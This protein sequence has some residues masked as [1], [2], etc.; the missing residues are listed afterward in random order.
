MS[1]APPIAP[2]AHRHAARFTR[3]VAQA[4]HGLANG[5]KARQVAARAGLAITQNAQHHQAG[6]ERVQTLGRHVPAFER[7]GAKALDHHVGFG[8]QL[9]GYGL[10]FLLAQVQRHR[11]LVARLHLPPDGSAFLDQGPVAQRVA[12]RRTR[13]PRIGGGFDLDDIGTQLAQRLAAK[14]ARDKVRTGWGWA[15]RH[16][17]QH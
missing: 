3:Q 10:P 12:A 15:A 1:S 13:L 7:A 8:N 2:H 11:A 14:R 6:V 9:A 4:A 17:P 5:A 16:K